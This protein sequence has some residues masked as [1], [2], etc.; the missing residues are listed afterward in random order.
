MEDM[1]G[2]AVSC[3]GEGRMQIL[4]GQLEMYCSGSN[5]N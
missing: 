3:M 4:Q 5:Q 1:S 2:R